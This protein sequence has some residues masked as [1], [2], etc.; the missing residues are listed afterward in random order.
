[1]FYNSNY[2]GFSA[3]H[4]TWLRFSFALI[5]VRLLL[6][7][8]IKRFCSGKGSHGQPVNSELKFH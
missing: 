5:C 6:G 3:K 4:L 8:G 2:N 7:L 1:L